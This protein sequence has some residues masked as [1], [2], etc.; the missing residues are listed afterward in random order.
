MGSAESPKTIEDLF[1]L[2]QIVRTELGGSLAEIK[3]EMA[4]IKQ[5]M[6]GVKEDVNKLTTQV[7]NM[8]PRI[9]SCETRIATVENDVDVRFNDME[10]ALGNTATEEFMIERS[11]VVIGLAEEQNENIGAICQEMLENGLG[12]IN[13]QVTQAQRL[14]SRDGRPGLIKLELS[15]KEHKI[16]AL[17]CK[18]NLRDT[19]YRGVFIRSSMSHTDRMVHHNFK[20]I[21]KELPNGQEFKLLSNGKV[22]KNEPS[23]M[24]AWSRGPPVSR[25]HSRNEERVNTA[26]GNSTH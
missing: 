14:R 5:K 17:R 26:M 18:Q 2:L 7:E 8:E 21:L 20:T 10:R 16:A 13:A 1:G 6:E 24:G 9:E 19:G 4:D 11:L 12:L 15:S 22:V 25:I 23:R 3:K